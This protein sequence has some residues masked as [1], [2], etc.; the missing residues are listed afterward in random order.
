MNIKFFGVA[1]FTKC[2]HALQ[3]RQNDIEKQCV[4]DKVFVK[5]HL[6]WI[7]FDWIFLLNVGYNEIVCFFS[8]FNKDVYGHGYA[9]IYVGCCMSCVH[10]VV[11]IVLQ[12][13]I[14]A[15]TPL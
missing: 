7:S 4:S 14:I 12:Q 6:T 9:L 10:C 13:F 15:V 3:L 8:K 5:D 1:E 2:P 11:L